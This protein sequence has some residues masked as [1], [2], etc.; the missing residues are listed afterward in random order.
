MTNDIFEEMEADALREVELPTDE[1]LS[2]VQ[3][4][5]A[6]Q[7]D[8]QL[9]VEIGEKALK[10]LKK[11]LFDVETKEF[12]DALREL[13]LT[14]LTLETGES[15]EIKSFVSASIS[16]AR[17]PEAHKWLIDHGHGDIIKVILT[18]DLGRD[19]LMK[20]QAM[21][22]LNSIGLK[23]VTKESVHAGTLKVFVRE[24]VEA[25]QS[26]PLELFGAFLGQKATIKKGK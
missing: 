11:E 6:K 7:L 3:K 16:K 20:S 9:A 12:P 13:G 10:D 8:L 2:G 22:E 18:V 23:P 15:V 19:E 14:G 5:A 4:I 25:G 1:K 21:A 17:A 26:I 24:Q